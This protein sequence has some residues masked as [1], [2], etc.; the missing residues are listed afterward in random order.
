MLLNLLA[1]PDTTAEIKNEIE[2]VQ[3][4]ELGGDTIWTRH[5]LGELR[6]L[7]SLM[8]ETLR[9]N[10]FTE[11][12]QPTIIHAS[13][14]QLLSGK[15]CTATMQRT[16]LVPYTFKDGLTVPAGL[17][18]NF[19]ALQHSLDEDIHGPNAAAFDPKRWIQRRQGF[20]TSKYQ[21]ASTSD[22]WLNWGGGPHACPG[23]F[24]ADIAIKLTLVYLLTNYEI[25]YP[26]GRSERPADGKRN[27]IITPD[28][29]LPI[30]F[31]EASR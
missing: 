16:A 31:K 6:L 12:R 29:T 14:L 15:F 19:A 8:R 1:R 26:E 11:G 7:D 9:L 21:F 18:V 17:S 4:D 23:R 28:M 27:L 3:K 20:D 2:R 5:A 13:T 25:K 10:S 22:D 30:M 24:L